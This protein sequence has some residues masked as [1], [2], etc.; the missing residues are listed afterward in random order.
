[1]PLYTLKIGIYKL[2]DFINYIKVKRK[3]LLNSIYSSV[4]PDFHF[5]ETPYVIFFTDPELSSSMYI[6]IFITKC[7]LFLP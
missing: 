4:S 6:N 5:K 7:K 1:M 3:N 2:K